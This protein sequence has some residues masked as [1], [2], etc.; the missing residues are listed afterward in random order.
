MPAAPNRIASA[1]WV[2][3]GIQPGLPDRRLD[4]LEWLVGTQHRLE[5]LDRLGGHFTAD[6][7]AGHHCNVHHRHGERV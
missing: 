6:P 3:G 5:H 1:Q 2:A 4:Q 7:V